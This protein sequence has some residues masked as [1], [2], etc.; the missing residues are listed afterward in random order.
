MDL[1]THISNDYTEFKFALTI[2]ARSPGISSSSL[3]QNHFNF[4]YLNTSVIQQSSPF[5]NDIPFNRI[6][7][8]DA[9]YK[10]LAFQH[11]DFDSISYVLDSAYISE[12]IAN[13]YPAG[14]SPDQPLN[15]LAGTNQLLYKPQGF[16]LDDFSGQ[17]IFT[18]T[19]ANDIGVIVVACQG[20]KNSGGQMKLAS[21]V[22]KDFECIVSNGSNNSPYFYGLTMTPWQACE[23]EIFSEDI[24]YKDE[25]I[26]GVNDTVY[27]SQLSTDIHKLDLVTTVEG[28]APF[29]STNFNWIITPGL[30]QKDPY[31]FTMIA[32]D[33][34]CPKPGISYYNYRIK[35]SKAKQITATRK[36]VNCNVFEYTTVGNNQSDFLKKNIVNSLEIIPNVLLNA[37]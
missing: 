16:Y 7:T 24:Y 10:S 13:S 14:H 12:K 11:Q 30:A 1:S 6:N 23:G 2:D 35:V 19:L 34:N 25:A 31:V 9:I 22:R 26:G 4:C 3:V 21:V 36:Q 28:F 37:E 18:P 29:R 15:I 5:S 20:F 27:L 8:N 33:S 17:L 32:N